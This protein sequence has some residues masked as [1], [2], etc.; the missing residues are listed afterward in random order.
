MDISTFTI[1][2]VV[3]MALGAVIGLE[4]QLRQKSAGLRT[5]ILV[6]MGAALY[7]LISLKMTAGGEGD[8]TRIIGQIVTGVGFIGGGIIFK[9]GADVH[10]LT[11]AA[12]VWCSS[13][14][15]SMAGAG[16]ITE[17]AIGAGLVLVVNVVL[18][19]VDK[20]I[21]RRRKLRQEKHPEEGEL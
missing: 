16:M 9:K 18:T 3:A 15:G 8:V 13:A 21:E 2:L 17:A 6:S 7:V 5:N 14:I 1:N 19:R 12:T 11:T 20:L 10:G 4:R